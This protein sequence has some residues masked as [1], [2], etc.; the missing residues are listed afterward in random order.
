MIGR[1]FGFTL[2]G[3]STVLGFH[4]LVLMLMM[5]AIAVEPGSVQH[6]AYW[7]GLLRAFISLVH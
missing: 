3:V 5:Y 4:L 2:W 7:D 6:T 1:V